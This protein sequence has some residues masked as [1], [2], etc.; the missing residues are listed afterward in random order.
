MFNILA[1]YSM[2]S[3]FIAENNFSSNVLLDLMYTIMF[4]FI[5][6]IVAF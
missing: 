6:E 5:N 3:L 2:P 1:L 4:S